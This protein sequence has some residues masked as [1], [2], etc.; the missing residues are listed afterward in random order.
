[1]EDLEDL[2][3]KCIQMRSLRDPNLGSSTGLFETDRDAGFGVASRRNEPARRSGFA[4][5]LYGE[6][7]RI[8]KR[9]TASRISC[10]FS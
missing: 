3:P 9:S 5:Y 6:A 4:S 2:T 1:M 8:T 7:K 10:H